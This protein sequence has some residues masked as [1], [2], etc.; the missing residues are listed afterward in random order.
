MRFILKWCVTCTYLPKVYKQDRWWSYSIKL[1]CKSFTP[2]LFQ[3]FCIWW[4]I[5]CHFIIIIYQQ[6]TCKSLDS[7]TQMPAVYWSLYQIYSLQELC[8]TPKIIL[9]SEPTNS[10]PGLCC[11]TFP[12]TIYIIH[13]L[14]PESRDLYKEQ[15]DRQRENRWNFISCSERETARV[16]EFK[17]ERVWSTVCLLSSV[18]WKTLLVQRSLFSLVIWIASAAEA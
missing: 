13:C 3:R 12:R 15:A 4:L 14:W 17:M 7:S 1:N 11:C 6:H 8:Q 10:L 2:S 5:L 16:R 9:S 18:R